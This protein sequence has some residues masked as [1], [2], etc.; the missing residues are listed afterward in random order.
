L[1][2][3]GRN[4]IPLVKRESPLFMF[5]KEFGHFFAIVL[6]VAAALAFVAEW[7]ALGE[8]MATLG[9]AIIGVVVVN[10]IFSFWQAYHAG[11]AIDA[12]QKF[13]LI[14][15]TPWGN[16]IFGTAPLPAVVWLC[17]IPF[18]L[19]MI[20]MEELRKWLARSATLR[21]AAAG[22]AGGRHQFA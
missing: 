22:E 20:A 7:R 19:G 6:W 16:S 8:G 14:D 10:G 1:T 21:T 12:L 13:L 2:E 3:F 9:F 5:L 11:K 15:Y 18:A 4:E 17:M